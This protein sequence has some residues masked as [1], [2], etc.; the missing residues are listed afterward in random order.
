[1]QLRHT[2][3]DLE[4]LDAYLAAELGTPVVET[5]ILQDGVNVTVAVSTDGDGPDYVCRRPN[6][7]RRIDYF[8]SLDGEYAVLRQ[9]EDTDIDAPRP[10]RFCGDESVLGGPFFL[11]TRLDGT[12]VPWGG[13][14]PDRYRLPEGRTAL[15][16]WLIDT[17]VGIHDLDTGPFEQVC[18]V[19]HPADSVTGAVDR[20][21]R[22]TAVTGHE[23]P[24]LWDVADWLLA[25]APA[26]SSTSLVHG[27]YKPDNVLVTETGMATLSGVI[28]WEATTIGDPLVDLGFLLFFWRHPADPTPD[29][30]ALESV[31]TTSDVVD[32]L[33][34]TNE[35]GFWPFTGHAGSLTRRELVSRYE[36]QTGQ[37]FEHERFYRALAPFSVAS[38]WETFHRY[39]VEADRDSHWEPLIEYVT[40]LA[41][42]I[43]EGRCEL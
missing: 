41:A 2:D 16:H 36:R 11:M 31:S 32:Q 43:V 12:A 20:I 3:F 13:Q 38:V 26:R 28:D 10:V 8:S 42:D 21:E 27:D 29:V 24:I 39:R 9:L 1:M 5:E 34:E 7:E 35:R 4:A 14:L 23:L 18:D 40:A 33:R 37:S 17:L 30:T 25:N 15:S 6:P 19:Q 22:A